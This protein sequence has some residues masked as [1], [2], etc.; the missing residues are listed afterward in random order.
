[1]SADAD[2]G[3]KKKELTRKA[4]RV[5]SLD[6]SG[7]PHMQQQTG[8]PM[9]VLYTSGWSDI[10]PKVNA[11]KITK[12]LLLVVKVAVVSDGMRGGTN[13]LLYG[14]DRTRQCGGWADHNRRGNSL[15]VQQITG[16][17]LL[18]HL[19]STLALELSK[20]G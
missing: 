19:G 7:I 6:R 18:A 10:L 3:K 14:G 8:R 17:L 12:Y 11:L 15:I 1:M 20:V 5:Y 9:P 2:S 16:N 13:E 4:K